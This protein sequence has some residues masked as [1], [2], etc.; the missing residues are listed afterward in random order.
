MGRFR[1]QSQ[2]KEGHCGKGHSSSSN[3]SKSAERRDAPKLRSKGLSDFSVEPQLHHSPISADIVETLSRRFY[4]P[5]HTAGH[6]GRYGCVCRVPLRIPR[7]GTWIASIAASRSAGLIA[8]MPSWGLR[9]S[10]PESLTSKAHV[11]PK[12]SEQCQP[13]QR[14]PPTQEPLGGIDDTAHPLTA[15]DVPACTLVQRHPLIQPRI[16]PGQGDLFK[17][18]RLRLIR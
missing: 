7:P 14:S 10:L 6:A 1:P 2:D 4:E 9:D 13:G 15:F 17:P 18:V 12:P 16:H 8:G 5:H 11:I 3:A